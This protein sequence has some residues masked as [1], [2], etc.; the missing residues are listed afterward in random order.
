MSFVMLPFLSSPPAS[1]AESEAPRPLPGELES[2]ELADFDKFD[3]KRAALVDLALKLGRTHRLNRYLFG[4]A[5]PE[6]GGFDCSGSIYFILS[7]AG[8]QPARSSAAQYD[9][10]REAG[11]LTEVPASAGSLEAPVFKKLQPGDLVFWAGTYRPTD[12]RTNKVTHVQMYLGVEKASGK[13]VMI[14]SSDGRSYSGKA[15]CGFG[16]YDFKVPSRQSK[17]RIIGFGPPPGLEK[18]QKPAQP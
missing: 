11:L 1:A 15:R 14:G 9:W 5:D 3:P 18:L 2:A 4:S 13:P 6:K 12:G 7:Q 16:V 10:I 8:I 17:A